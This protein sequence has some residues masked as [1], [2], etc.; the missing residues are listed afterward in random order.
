MHYKSISSLIYAN[1]F[2]KSFE[3]KRVSYKDETKKVAIKPIYDIYCEKNL[4]IMHMVHKNSACEF[5]FP[6]ERGVS[7]SKVSSKLIVE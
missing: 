4:G 3:R 7:F 1:L 5:K 2:T 6:K